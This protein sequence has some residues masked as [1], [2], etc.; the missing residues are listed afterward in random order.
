MF[1]DQT[2]LCVT[3]SA[4]DPPCPA[5]K[6]TPRF[7]QGCLFVAHSAEQLPTAM[8]PG[9]WEN[10]CSERNFAAP[11]SPLLTE[12]GKL[13]KRSSGRPACLTRSL[14][15]R[16]QNLQRKRGPKRGFRTAWLV[17]M[18]TGHQRW[19]PE[20]RSS[21]VADSQ[22]AIHTIPFTTRIQSTQGR[23]AGASPATVFACSPVIL[24]IILLLLF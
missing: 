24:V 3:V 21:R 11:L 6:R 20:T 5:Q 8:H 9:L 18:S 1:A 16:R 7:T 12:E 23:A 19:L 10:L 14:L 2:F 22:T 15:R 4:A 13:T 17:T